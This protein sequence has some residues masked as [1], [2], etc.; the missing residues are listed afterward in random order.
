M[1]TR[2]KVLTILMALILVCALYVLSACGGPVLE[3]EVPKT[4]ET[5]YGR[6][7]ELPDVIAKEGETEYDVKFVI[8]DKDGEEVNPL[9][10]V[11]SFDDYTVEF[12]VIFYG[13]K[14]SKTMTLKVVDRIAPSITAAKQNYLI[15]L[16]T[17]ST[18]TIPVEDFTFSDL[19]TSV[20]A[21]EV[22]YS[23][24]Y[25]GAA[26]TLDESLTFEISQ[27]GEYVI[28]VQAEDEAKNKNSK[29]VS[30]MVFNTLDEV[31]NFDFEDDEQVNKVYG[32][33]DH[34]WQQSFFSRKAYS[35]L[36]IEQPENGGDYCLQYYP[37]QN[38]PDGNGHAIS[39]LIIDMGV[40]I[41]KDT[42]ITFQYYYQKP[43][44]YTPANVSLKVG[45]ATRDGDL[46]D[47]SIL[48]KFN[49]DG[50]GGAKK[51]DEWHTFEVKLTN[52]TQEIEFEMWAT[53]GLEHD[54]TKITM[55]IDNLKVKSSVEALIQRFDFENEDN[56][57]KVSPYTGWVDTV[58]D[59]VKYNDIGIASP[60]DG[61]SGCL[62]FAPVHSNPGENGWTYS[63]IAIDFGAKLP[64]GTPI[65]F[66]FY[67][68]KPASF[69]PEASL[70]VGPKVE[71]DLGESAILSASFDIGGGYTF[72]TWHYFT[73]RL[74]SEA[75]EIKFEL[76]S[77]TGD[78]D[79]TEIA[80]YID[81][82]SILEEDCSYTEFHFE[83]DDEFIK[84]NGDLDGDWTDCDWEIRKYADEGIDGPIGGGQYGLWYTTLLN[85]PDGGGWSRA[86]I[87]FDF[88]KP[89]PTGTEIYFKYYIDTE[90][91]GFEPEVKLR[92]GKK[93]NDLASKYEIANFG[94][95]DNLELDKWHTLSFTLDEDLSVIKFETHLIAPA[96]DDKTTI[97]IYVDDII[98]YIY[99]TLT[100]ENAGEIDRVNGDPDGDWTDC[101]WEIRKYVDEGI[102]APEGGGD[103]CLWYTT[104]LNSPD[105]GDW[106]RADITFDF[107]RPL[108][109]GSIVT[110]QYYFDT[111]EAGF[112]PECSLKVGRV[113]GDLDGKYEVAKFDSS[114]LAFNTWN[115]ISLTIDED[116]S[117]IKLE[118]YIAASAENDKTKLN[119]YVDN[120]TVLPYNEFCFEDPNENLRVNGD[121]SGDWTDCVWNI[122]DYSETGI[123]APE[124][125]GDSCLW[126][127][128]L[129]NS[130]D[131]GDWSR[132]DITFDFGKPLA[133]GT[134]ITFKYYIDAATAGFTPECSLKAGRNVGDLPGAAEIAKF[135]STH[136]AF[137]QWHTL[138]L[139]LDDDLSV[140]KLELY[141]AAAKENDKTRINIYLDNMVATEPAE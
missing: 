17:A 68:K 61:G 13:K 131:G 12:W 69:N 87:T 125:G 97:N 33:E 37:A 129:L 27:P 110:F 56:I 137:D 43:A 50:K 133:K 138:T 66:M 121:P 9:D 118:L 20:G 74:D 38:N 117:K 76:Y 119:I 94:G 32:Y 128:T 6:P 77:Y 46:P 52:D 82:I 90:T 47:N 2:C 30:V 63:A 85:S 40:V 41:P 53:P 45:P 54:G 123:T 22:T 80:L 108:K 57:D 132:A 105:G 14:V 59:V 126:Y 91:A 81:C 95:T 70:K 98:A 3:F 60:W 88:G 141:I 120:I 75:Q 15:T 29:T 73:C 92:V 71:G 19:A 78:K 107:L 58:Y 5:E 102:T 25:N 114:H 100:F 135:D 8:K 67:Y 35:T 16:D 26:V 127:T 44:E 101:D 104:L 89:L 115:T 96:S 7:F 140:I 109:K 130:P 28:K 79:G 4:Y 42:V 136:L 124:G 64:A 113:V 49:A 51:F 31:I 93:V 62:R 10:N 18:F 84:V 39:Y 11:T 21:I 23:V 48:S 55:Y 1:K 83:N 106:S 34:H 24:T 139:T 111:Q 103:S 36:S 134:Q 72:D 65:S 122:K 99:P 116:L 112:T 86:D